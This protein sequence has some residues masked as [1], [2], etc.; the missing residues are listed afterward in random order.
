MAWV[1]E[2]LEVISSEITKNDELPIMRTWAYDYDNNTFLYDNAGKPL[3]VE[4]NEA[5]KQWIYWA[6]INER[7]M[8]EVNSNQ[9]GT[10]IYETIG[11][12]F[13]NGAK[14]EEVKR[15]IT[16]TLMVCPYIKAI[17]NIAMAIIR[18]RLMISIKVSSIYEE[19]WV[20]TVV[21]V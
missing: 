10:Q 6:L 3:I 19:G 4:R 2:T 13:S 1:P 17:E 20:E 16:E 14:Q 15:F 5:L 7:Y 18:G 21:H 9:Y 8:H 12:P 11:F